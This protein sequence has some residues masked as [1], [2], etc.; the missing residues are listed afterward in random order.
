[1]GPTNIALVRLFLADQELRRAQA[2]LDAATKDVRIQERRVNDL[3]EKQQTAQQKLRE[4]QAGAGNMELD[5]KSRDAQIEKLRDQ[6]QNAKNNKEYQ[7]LLLQINTLKVDRNKVEDETMKLLEVAEKDQ[8]ELKT[9]VEQLAAEQ[10]KLQ[11]MR[12]KI[13]GR[14]TELQSEIDARRPDRDEAAA[15]VPPKARDIFE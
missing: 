8:Q 3:A 9:L 15:A 5:L 2:Q 6:Q 4:A 11:E 12:G 7:T 13:Q 1:M 10:T 14:I